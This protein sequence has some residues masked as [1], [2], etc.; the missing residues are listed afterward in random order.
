MPT[1]LRTGKPLPGDWV[2]EGHTTWVGTPP[3]VWNCRCLGVRRRWVYGCRAVR[4]GPGP[5]KRSSPQSSPT[6]ASQ[7]AA[8]ASTGRAF[9]CGEVPGGLLGYLLAM[10]SGATAGVFAGS[11]PWKQDSWIETV[12]RAVAGLAIGAGLFYG[13]GT[14][15]HLALPFR[16]AGVARGTALETAPLFFLPLVAAFFGA[17]V[18]LDN[19]PDEGDGNAPTR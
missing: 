16:V 19:A 7:H 18:E 8:S 14:W 5:R 2:D 11:P 10:G 1:L 17:L 9:H 3:G 13:A 12:L 6:S 15:L 4:R